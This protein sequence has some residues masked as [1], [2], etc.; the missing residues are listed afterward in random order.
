M[1]FT[2]DEEPFSIILHN[3]FIYLNSYTLAVAA[4]PITEL[5]L[6]IKAKQASLLLI[7]ETNGGSLTIHRVASYHTVMHG[8]TP[9]VD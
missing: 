5:M 4:H 8:A 7:E 6:C 9:N 2:G 3:I 1:F